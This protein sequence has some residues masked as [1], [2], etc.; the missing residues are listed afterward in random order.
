MSTPN[1]S[2]DLETASAAGRGQRQEVLCYLLS[3]MKR[4]VDEI[5]DQLECIP[6]IRECYQKWWELQCQV[7]E[8]YSGK[9]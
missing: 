9:K 3:P 7:N 5:V 8:F 2:R 1:P 4:Q 6:V